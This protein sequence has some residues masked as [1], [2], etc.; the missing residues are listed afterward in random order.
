MK[1]SILIPTRNRSDTLYHAIRSVLAQTCPDFELVVMDNAT[2]DDTPQVVASFNDQRIKYVRTEQALSMADNWEVGLA[3]TAGDYVFVMGDDDAMLPDGLEIC[4]VLAKQ[5]APEI[6]SWARYFY[7]WPNA[8]IPHTRNML[9]LHFSQEIYPL[10]G[11]E[12]LQQYYQSKIS[13]ESLPMI[14][15]SFVSRELIDRIKGITGRYFSFPIPDV[16][17]GVANAYF[18]NSYLYSNRSISLSGSSGSS[19]GAAATLGIEKSSQEYF[20]REVGQWKIQREELL[21]D[22][23]EGIENLSTPEFGNAMVMFAAKDI[24]FPND[25]SITV[26]MPAIVMAI[27]TGLKVNPAQYVLCVEYVSNLAKRYNLDITLPKE[28]ASRVTSSIKHGP[29]YDSDGRIQQ[30]IVN[31]QHAG[32]EN[33]ADAAKL[34]Y[35]I[36]PPIL[37]SR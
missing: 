22:P 24:L 14:Y 31:C 23:V 18:A 5:H 13:F 17:S 32:I 3:N 35:A 29:I 34:A 19:L 30:I 7:T 1:F 6:I 33:A 2:I 28:V 8:V 15:N 36:L 25:D 4:R 10:N 21:A 9:Y 11:K 26:D 16:F 12:I 37:V 20:E 27:A